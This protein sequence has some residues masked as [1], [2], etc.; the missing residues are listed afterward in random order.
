MCLVARMRIN[1]SN[2]IMKKI[3]NKIKLFI[4]NEIKKFA[5]ALPIVILIFVLYVQCTKLGTNLVLDANGIKW[6]ISQNIDYTKEELQEI[7]DTV[8]LSLHKKGIETK[9]F[10]VTLVLCNSTNEFLWKALVWDDKNQGVTRH[11]FEHTVINRSSIKENRMIDFENS[12]LSDVIIHEICHIYLSKRLSK[13]KVFFLES[14]KNEGY[15]EYISE[16][17]TLDIEKGLSLFM[18]NNKTEIEKTDN[19]KILYFYFTSRLKTDY[20][21]GYKKVPF[22]EFIDTEYDEELLEE[23][24]RNALKKGE[25]KFPSK[26]YD[27]Q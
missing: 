16:H 20:L 27:I 4:V 3:L 6:Y 17:S 15:C 10:D 7:A 2:I 18:T 9:D 12:T 14:W 13:I 8:T 24:I 22:D 26:E 19:D 25:Y 23:E 11:L 1:K 21:L 5:K